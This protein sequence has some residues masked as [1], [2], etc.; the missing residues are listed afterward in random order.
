MIFFISNIQTSTFKTTIFHPKYPSSGY[1]SSPCLSR[2]SPYFSALAGIRSIFN[3]FKLQ[4]TAVLRA[5]VQTVM[6][7]MPTTFQ[8]NTF[9]S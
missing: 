3:F 4:K 8:P 9:H 5:A 1:A 2:S 6:A 7:S